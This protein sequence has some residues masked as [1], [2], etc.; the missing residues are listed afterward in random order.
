MALKIDTTGKSVEV[1]L[2]S[3]SPGSDLQK[4]IE[5]PGNIV[6]VSPASMAIKA[7][8]SYGCFLL[9]GKSKPENRRATIWM[10]RGDVRGSVVFLKEEELY[11]LNPT[12][13][14]ESIEKQMSGNRTAN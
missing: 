14:P 3:D 5:G 2:D 8:Y 13:K 1:E 10:G 4:H 6:A 7:G 12:T 9:R 11:G